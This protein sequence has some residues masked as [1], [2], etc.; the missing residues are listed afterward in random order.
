MPILVYLC[1]V[2]VYKYRQ[3]AK[4]IRSNKNILFEVFPLTA[5]LAG[6]GKPKP[7]EKRRSR[8]KETAEN[9]AEA[10]RVYVEHLFSACDAVDAR[11]FSKGDRTGVKY[12]GARYLDPKYSRWLSGDPALSDYIPKAPVDDEAKKHNENLPGMG[13]VFNVVNLHLYHY[14]G[15]NPVKYEDPDGNETRSVSAKELS[16]I[17]DILGTIGENINYN[18]TIKSS[19]ISGSASVVWKTIYLDKSIFHNPLA[20][21]YGKETL[22]HEAFHQVQ[23]CSDN[24]GSGIIPLPKLFPSA[25]DRLAINERIYFLFFDVYES[26]DYKLADISKYNKLSD[27]PYLE[28]QA[29]M[30]GIYASLYTKFKRGNKMSDGDR[31][32]L[33]EMNCILINSGIDSEATKWVSE[34]L[35]D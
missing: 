20:S 22:I 25:W 6:S 3:S 8:Y 28:G 30:V 31:V 34:N 33:K 18:V 14:A 10:Y 24:A 11:M 26:G 7:F 21:D 19:P 17:T 1:I 15:N 16:Y 12:Y 23:Y 32:A 5:I 4:R 29:E 9:K 13:G 35:Q 27:I 2:I